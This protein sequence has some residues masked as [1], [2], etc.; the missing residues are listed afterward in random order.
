MTLLNPLIWLSIGSKDF[1]PLN[2]RSFMPF[3]IGGEWIPNQSSPINQKPVKVRMV[4][5][6]KSILTVILNLKGSNQ[7]LQEL[8]AHIKKKL[9]CGGAVKEG[10]VEIQGDKVD[11]VRKILTDMGIKSS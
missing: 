6:G 1:K 10:D 2:R 5:R 4:K 3:T 9:G 7:D 11:Q 8:A